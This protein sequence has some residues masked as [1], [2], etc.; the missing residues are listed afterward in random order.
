MKALI[1][2]VGTG[3]RPSADAV[4]SLANALAFSITHHNP[5]K[6]FFVVSRESLENTLP[7]ILKRM[8]I[9]NYEVIRVKDPDDIQRIYEDLRW[10]FR[11]MRAKYQNLAVDYTSGTKAMT[12]ALTILGAIFEAD[13]LS[14]I[15]GKR[16]GGIVQRGT[17]TIKIV[18]PYFAISEQ[19]IKLAIEFF[20]RNQ[21]RSTIG[22]L[23]DIRKRTADPEII[24]RIEPLEELA[25]AYEHW[26]RFQHE[27]ACK[28][29]ME[30]KIT[31]LNKNKRFLGRLMNEIRSERG[32]PEPYYIA[33]LINNA[34]R[35][36]EIEEK[37]DD[38]V[39]RLYRTVELIA[40]Y[41]LKRDYE[42]DPQKP[43]PDRIS[44]ELK[45]K[46]KITDGEPIRLSLK[47]SYELLEAEGDALG[48]RF[49]EDAKMQG[50]LSRRNQSILAHGI[51]PIN[52]E[53]FTGLPEKTIE[54]ANETVKDLE[55]LMKD[56]QFIKWRE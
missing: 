9:R 40:H 43:D 47:M 42:I 6:I 45:R 12:S 10:K 23:M 28:E 16:V 11:E 44:T 2:S 14:Y 29:I 39:A 5:D 25:R 54:Y 27:E 24:R 34:K 13:E 41:K 1:I 26:D 15:T 53:I 8:E 22:I 56:S 55:Q 36:G 7:L 51:N 32:R 50:L 18:R 4:E 38:A 37:Y 3:T 30:L 21:F 31:E 46:W 52:K 33:D 20:N 17:E 48:E 19:K 49:L 35:R